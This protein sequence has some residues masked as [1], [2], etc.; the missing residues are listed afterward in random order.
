MIAFRDFVPQ[1]LNYKGPP[2]TI[3][4]LLKVPQFETLEE[5]VAAANEWIKREA[6]KVIHVETVVLPHTYIYDAKDVGVTD[7]AIVEGHKVAF[8]E[9][10][11]RVW[12][13]TDKNLA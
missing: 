2:K 3:L 8:W 6:I 9:Q 7:Q 4:G 13:E 12:Y 5:A 11:A 1:P 10:F